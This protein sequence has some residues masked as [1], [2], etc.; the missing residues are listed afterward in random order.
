LFAAVRGDVEF[1]TGGTGG[2]TLHGWRETW[3]AIFAKRC[4]GPETTPEQWD[5]RDLPAPSARVLFGSLWSAERFGP[6]WRAGAGRLGIRRAEEITALADGAQWIGNQAEQHLPG[7]AGVL[8]IYHASEPAYAA[9]RVLHGEGA[10]EVPAWVEAR[11]P[12][13]SRGGV[14]ALDVE[15]AG[16]ERSS[17]SASKRRALAALRDYLAPHVR[18]SGYAARLRQGQSIGSGMVGGRARRWWASG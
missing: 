6:Q 5:E 4:R 1:S 12:A 18:H 17:R 2:S 10:A 16:L 14:A 3:L 8:D 7:A 9:A 11:R 13:L 15:L